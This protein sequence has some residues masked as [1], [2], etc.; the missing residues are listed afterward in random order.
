MALPALVVSSDELVV[1]FQRAGFVAR[2]A[3]GRTILERGTRVVVIP[4]GRLLAPEAVAATL[5]SAG[6]SYSDFL[7]YLSEAP[8]EP[9][10]SGTRLCLEDP[11][12]GD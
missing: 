8:T 2:R 11:D 7:D 9:A 5:R 10:R 4:D 1:A 12:P 6:I 3:T